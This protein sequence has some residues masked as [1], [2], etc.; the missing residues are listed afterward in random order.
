MTPDDMQNWAERLQMEPEPRESRAPIIL[1]YALLVA[2]AVGM[3]YGY[4]E[5]FNG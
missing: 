2:T 3:A 1:A 4:W 5:I